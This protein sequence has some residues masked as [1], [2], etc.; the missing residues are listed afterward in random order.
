MSTDELDE[1]IAKPIDRPCGYYWIK[2]PY[3]RWGK[4]GVPE[5]WEVGSWDP[6]VQMWALMGQSDAW[7][8]WQ[9]QEIGARIE[10]PRD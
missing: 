9:L 3:A 5:H 10:E 2:F 7:Y 1:R 6:D 4:P 8:E